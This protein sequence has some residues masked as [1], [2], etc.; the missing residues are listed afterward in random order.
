MK[1]DSS[2]WMNLQGPPSEFS[3]EKS[4]RRISNQRRE[5]EGAGS[6]I[7]GRRNFAVMSDFAR[8]K[9]AKTVKEAPHSNETRSSHMW[10]RRII[11]VF[12][13]RHFPSST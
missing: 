4:A 11:C 1:I 7:G 12:F 2:V 10:D 6:A 8:G 13:G 9:R 3:T 5:I